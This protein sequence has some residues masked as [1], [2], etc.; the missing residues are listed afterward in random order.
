MRKTYLFLLLFISLLSKSVCAQEI[1][2]R[3]LK[4]LEYMNL[5]QYEEA[6]S[7]FKSVTDSG[8]DIDK[9]HLCMGICY[10]NT[11]NFS[12]AIDE[13]EKEIKKDPTSNQSYYLLAMIYEYQGK[14][15]EAIVYWKKLIQRSKDHELKDTALKH[16]KYLE[17]IK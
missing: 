3:M 2:D 17:E 6:L 9:V 15:K 11:G 10:L 14:I 1:I 4:G 8:I 7:E 16:I 12:E 13:F 5:G